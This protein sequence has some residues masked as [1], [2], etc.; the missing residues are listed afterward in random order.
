MLLFGLPGQHP[1]ATEKLY[2]IGSSE[3]TDNAGTYLNGNKYARGIV[4]LDEGM[5]PVN[6]SYIQ[7]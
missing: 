7:A 4:F 2:H 6:T 1:M 3:I 5:I